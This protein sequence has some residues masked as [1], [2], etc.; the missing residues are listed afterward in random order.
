MT[1]KLWAWLSIAT[2]MILLVGIIISFQMSE[3]VGAGIQLVGWIIFSGLI[4]YRIVQDRKEQK[5]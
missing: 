5:K 3:Y 1:R 4:I 2:L